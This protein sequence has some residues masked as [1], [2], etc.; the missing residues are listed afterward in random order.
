MTFFL[1]VT[2]NQK[3]QFDAVATH[4]L[5]S[6]MWGEFREKTGIKVIRRGIF[7][8][9]TLAKCF[10]IT[11]HPIPYTGL[12]I[13]YLPKGYIPDE[14]LLEHL[15][16]IGKEEKCIFIQLEPNITIEKGKTAMEQLLSTS[17][18][19]LLPSQ[20]PL[21]TKYTFQ[22][23]LTKSEEELLKNMHPK[24]RYNIKLAQKH[25][26]QIIEEKTDKAFEIYWKLT[27]ETTKR[28][29]FFSHT[30]KYHKLMWETLKEGSTEKKGDELSAHLFLAN[31]TPSSHSRPVTLAAW[32]LFTFHDTVYYP[33]GAS[34]SE[35]RNVMA[36]NLMMWEAIRF[37]KKRGFKLFDM[38]G[39]LGENP[40]TNDSWYGFHRL[41]QGYGPK[42]VEFV[43][44]Y[45]LVISPILYKLYIMGD[46]LR[47]W[48][49]RM[50]K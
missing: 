26:V 25:N 40:D 48:Y 1:P 7:D 44:S 11:I 8:K 17:Y 10:Q 33:Y 2:K 50:K 38:W 12:T 22:L 15:Y 20:H 3:K 32:I 29:N 27:E 24:T 30:K 36:S 35:Y 37:G 6:F 46:T 45:D 28:Q 34:S 9:N 49:L 18:L 42:L 19:N 23:N 47:W 5:Q 21:F 31:Y 13:G 4:P 16:K 14:T 41:K 39:S 43:G